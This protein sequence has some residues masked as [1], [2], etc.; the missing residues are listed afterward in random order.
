MSILKPLDEREKKAAKI[1]LSMLKAH[2]VG[3]ENSI[4]NS[5]IREGFLKRFNEK[6]TGIRIRKMIHHLAVESPELVCADSKGYYIAKN[7]LE[8]ENHCK[9]LE[10]RMLAIARRKRATEDKIKKQQNDKYAP[11]L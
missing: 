4:S 7:W 10:E 11:K 8:A 1:L 5:K 9:S 3:K 6:F 2:Y